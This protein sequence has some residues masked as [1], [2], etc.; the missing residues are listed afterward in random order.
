M[1]SKITF[2]NNTG[3]E[4]Q[5]CIEPLAEY[6]DWGVDKSVEIE[7]ELITDKFNDEL[8]SIKFG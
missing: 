7:L 3:K 4:M 1:E 6:I 2:E 8:S 5:L